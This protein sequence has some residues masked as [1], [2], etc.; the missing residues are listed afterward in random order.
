MF[1]EPFC[2]LSGKGLW[3]A[4]ARTVLT[5]GVRRYLVNTAQPSQRCGPTRFQRRFSRCSLLV[6]WAADS[7][8]RRAAAP[9]IAV[10]YVAFSASVSCVG[11]ENGKVLVQGWGLVA[12]GR[13]SARFWDVLAAGPAG[14]FNARVLACSC[15]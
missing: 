11:V 6:S 12:D 15:A 2:D 3:I 14:S 4:T 7:K 1:L 10:L 13:G 8:T 9:G 5:A